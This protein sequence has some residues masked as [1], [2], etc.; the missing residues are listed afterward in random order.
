MLAGDRFTKRI[1]STKK[2]M[3]AQ[4]LEALVHASLEQLTVREDELCHARSAQRLSDACLERVKQRFD[5]TACAINNGPARATSIKKK[6]TVYKS[7]EQSTSRETQPQDS[8]P[9]SVRR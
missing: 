1:V 5:K 6:P 4:T 3:G 8:Q 2:Q 7:Y 9:Q